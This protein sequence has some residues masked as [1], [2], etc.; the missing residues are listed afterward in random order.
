MQY[1]SADSTGGMIKNKLHETSETVRQSV[2]SASESISK[3]SSQLCDCASEG[4]RKSPIA[5]VVGAAFFGAAVCYLI[6]ESRDEA[7]FRER[8]INRPLSDASSSVSDSF[9]SLFGNLKFW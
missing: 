8:Y 5:Y 4:I 7:T 6:L 9:H 2:V 1:E 3:G